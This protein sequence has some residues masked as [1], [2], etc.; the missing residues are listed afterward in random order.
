MHAPPSPLIYLPTDRTFR[1]LRQRVFNTEIEISSEP[2]PVEAEAHL[3]QAQVGWAWGRGPARQSTVP[4]L[5]ALSIP[6][7]LPG[8]HA[9][10]RAE[11]P[12]SKLSLL[13]HFRQALCL[14]QIS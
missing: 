8:P 3:A 9:P 6:G 1:E 7:R 13:W 4:Q 10:P 5:C 11:R 2:K 14:L 12:V